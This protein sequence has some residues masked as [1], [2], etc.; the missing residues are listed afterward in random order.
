MRN[1]H[2]KTKEDPATDEI[3]DPRSEEKIEDA[4]AISSDEE[5]DGMKVN[6]NPIS[7]SIQRSG[8]PN[9]YWANGPK[10]RKGNNSRLTKEPSLSTKRKPRNRPKKKKKN[11]KK[12]I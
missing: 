8:Y 1:A 2:T 6:N 9:R 5:T 12:T 3:T 7:H 4:I 10:R 11:Q